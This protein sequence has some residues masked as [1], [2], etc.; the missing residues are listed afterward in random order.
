[1]YVWTSA[2]VHMSAHSYACGMW[3]PEVNTGELLPVILHLV[4]RD[5]VSYCN[6]SAL[7]WADRMAE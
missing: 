5:R 7:I 4:V 6:W 3:S 2:F 1:M